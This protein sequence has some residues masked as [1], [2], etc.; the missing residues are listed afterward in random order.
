MLPN[1]IKAWNLH[2]DGGSFA[3]LATEVELPKLK[4]KMDSYKGG[5]MDLEIESDQGQEKLESGFTLREFSRAVLNKWGVINGQ[6]V[7]IRLMMAAQRADASG[8]TDAI[9]VV[10]R[11]QWNEIDM[12]N[13]KGGDAA[14]M[15]VKMSLQYYRYIENGVDVIEIDGP[16]MIHKV[17]GVDLLEARRK[18]IGL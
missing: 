5:G 10:M 4:R 16:N 6:G 1:E 3:G 9:E 8:V 7:A 18:A 13:L 15:K 11:G 12:G 17:N 2:I 14:E